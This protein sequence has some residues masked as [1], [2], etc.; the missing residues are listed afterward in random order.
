[1]GLQ[2]LHW[3]ART[4]ARQNSKIISRVGTPFRESFG[5]PHRIR[6][7]AEYIPKLEMP[8]RSIDG[9]CRQHYVDLKAPSPATRCSRLN[10]GPS[11]ANAKGSRSQGDLVTRLFG[12]SFQNE[13]KSG[14]LQFQNVIIPVAP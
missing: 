7:V 6:W 10:C 14:E 4:Y 13:I 8:F 3:V 11:V 5:G 2:N 9:D 1:M 12:F